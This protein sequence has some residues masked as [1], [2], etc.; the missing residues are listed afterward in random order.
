MQYAIALCH[1]FL[2][3]ALSTVQRLPAPV[4]GAL[5][6]VAVVCLYESLGNRRMRPGQWR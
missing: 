5:F 3:E 4:T 6:V 1:N 2:H